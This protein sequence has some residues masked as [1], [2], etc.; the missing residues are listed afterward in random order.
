MIARH[1]ME[2]INPLNSSKHSIDQLENSLK[3]IDSCIHIL[4][5]QLFPENISGIALHAIISILDILAIKLLI[6]QNMFEQEKIIYGIGWSI[7]LSTT[8]IGTHTILKFWQ[9]GLI[10][11]ILTSSLPETSNKKINDMIK[12][13]GINASNNST[14]VQ[15]EYFKHKR[16]EFKK[17]ISDKKAWHTFSIYNHS[18]QLISNDVSNHIESFL[19]PKKNCN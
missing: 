12:H 10:N 8:L 16:Y 3:E 11:L 4:S 5:K 15:L 19:F 14:S 17:I 13:I 1:N 18:K 2:K 9:S 7:F 6:D